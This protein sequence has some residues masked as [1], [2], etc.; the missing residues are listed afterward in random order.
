MQWQQY[1]YHAR[2]LGQFPSLTFPP[3]KHEVLVSLSHL[4]VLH[5]VVHGKSNHIFFY[6]Q[7]DLNSTTFAIYS[8]KKQKE[9]PNSNSN[10]PTRIKPFPCNFVYPSRHLRV[11]LSFLSVEQPYNHQSTQVRVFVTSLFTI[12]HAYWSRK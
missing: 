3:N 10:P 12:F 6:Q 5:T 8:R 11:S 2:K 9:N 1:Y 4:N 7:I